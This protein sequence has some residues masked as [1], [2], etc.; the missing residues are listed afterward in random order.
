MI[1]LPET[2]CPVGDGHHYWLHQTD[3][4]IVC[5]KC[6]DCREPKKYRYSMEYML[7]K[8]WRKLLRP[9]DPARTAAALCLQELLVSAGAQ[10]R[11]DLI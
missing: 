9:D 10:V 2:T 5:Q 8:Y 6:G 11:D 4:A 1:R 3:G 7:D